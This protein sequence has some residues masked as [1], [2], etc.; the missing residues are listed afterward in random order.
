MDRVYKIF[1]FGDM[2][3]VY[4]ISNGQA[5][6]TLIPGDMEAE[7]VGRK[8][9]GADSFGRERTEPSMQI[10]VEGDGDERNFSAGRTYKNREQAFSL[11]HP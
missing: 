4:G 2:S 3:A 11:R 6:F 5:A 8:L 10:G 7:I 9:C 1:R